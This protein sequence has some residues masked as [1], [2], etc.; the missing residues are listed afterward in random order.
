[1]KLIDELFKNYKLKKDSLISY[2][3]ILDNNVYKYTKTIHNGSFELDLI[4]KDNILN[5][6]LIDTDFNDEYTQINQDV[7]G[8]F[9][10]SLKE[11]CEE[12]LLDIRD[13]CFIKELYISNQTNRIDKLIKDKYNVEAEFLWD[14]FPGFGVY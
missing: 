6:K 10:A 11:E 14:K 13:K 3:F 7:S 4:V 8:S 5:G 1:M 9:I 2:G 12:I